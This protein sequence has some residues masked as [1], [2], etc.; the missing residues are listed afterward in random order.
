MSTMKNTLDARSRELR[1]RKRAATSAARLQRALQETTH[2]GLRRVVR[3]PELI[4]MV[5]RGRTAIQQDIIER[6][7]PAPIPLGGRAVGWLIEEVEA[8]I[9]AR[10]AERNH[11]EAAE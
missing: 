8:W 1:A 5:G 6:R 11:I 4:A 10:A 9:A 2:A 7:F 3:W